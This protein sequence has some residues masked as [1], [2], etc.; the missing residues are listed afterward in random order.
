MSEE[1][2]YSSAAEI[3]SDRQQR[4]LLNYTDLE[5]YSYGP[6]HVVQQCPLIPP[7]IMQNPFLA[8]SNIYATH[9]SFY[10]HMNP[11]QGY[12][13]YPISTTSTSVPQNPS[14]KTYPHMNKKNKKK[15]EML[16][17]FP[18]DKTFVNQKQLENHIKQH[19]SCDIC[20]YSASKKVLQMHY[21]EKHPGVLLKPIQT[22]SEEDIARWREERRRNYPTDKKIALTQKPLN[23][24]DEE[25]SDSPEEVMI[26]KI[27]PSANPVVIKKQ[28]TLKEKSL[29]DKLLKI[30]LVKEDAFLVLEAIDF[31]FQEKHL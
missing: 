6:E 28:E 30:D 9:P 22:N 21:E 2:S 8:Y 29:H 10:P 27:F 13:S 5:T 31:L 26:P 1:F 4:N 24:L 17:C 11:L 12:F 23:I 14:S 20:L 18:C 19:L 16:N 7:S 3:Y 25:D 15:Q